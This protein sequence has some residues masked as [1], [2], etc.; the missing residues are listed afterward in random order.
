MIMHLILYHLFL[1]VIS[2]YYKDSD[3]INIIK[4][5]FLTDLQTFNRLAWLFLYSV[6]LVKYFFIPFKGKRGCYT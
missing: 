3:F 2:I 5:S 4:E 6:L 1:F